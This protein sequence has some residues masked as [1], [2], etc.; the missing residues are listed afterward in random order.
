M[1]LPI[2]FNHKFILG[3]NNTFYKKKYGKDESTIN[4]DK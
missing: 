4:T 3:I 2:S 1:D